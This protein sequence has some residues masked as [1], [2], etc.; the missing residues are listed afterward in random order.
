ME[1]NT[2]HKKQKENVEVTKHKKQ[3]ENVQV[4]INNIQ[5]EY[6]HVLS[7][8]NRDV[9]I[10]S[11]KPIETYYKR[12]VKILNIDTKSID[13]IIEGNK[14]IPRI[15]IFNNNDSNNN[16][17]CIYAVGANILKAAYLLQDI[18]NHYNSAV[19]NVYGKF[20][21]NRTNNNI[22]KKNCNILSP[23][24]IKVYSKTLIMNDNI[25]SNKFI[26]KNEFLKDDEYETL[27]NF[28]K[29][30]YDKNLHKY[31]EKIKERRVT[32]IKIKIK[33]KKNNI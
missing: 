20:N 8:G 22:N 14:R 1:N 17:V 11:N 21:Y 19:Y 16:Y 32:A 3:K 27:I 4:T 12:I 24:E 23:I 25:I 10:T 28:A 15:E 5:N 31:V 9:Y 13:H 2:K 18:I 7:K 29:Q 33:K 6:S 26:V 30:P